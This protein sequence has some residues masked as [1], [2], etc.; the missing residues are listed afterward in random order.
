GAQNDYGFAISGTTGSVAWDFRRMGELAVSLSPGGVPDYQDQPVSTV[1][2]GPDDG[3]TAAFQPG[4]A[5]PLGY[6]DLKVVEAM[7]FLRSIGEQAA[8][9]ATVA[10]A[11]AAFDV[12][13]AMTAS[14]R[15][16]RWES[17][18]SR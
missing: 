1:Y 16:G 9:G 3:E 6:D 14:V 5:I 8:Y 4:S 17:V 11:V 13:D 10:D 15:S 7:L 12:L 18:S 2:V